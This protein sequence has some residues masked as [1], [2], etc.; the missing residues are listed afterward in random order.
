MLKKISLL[1]IA[2]IVF[3]GLSVG[4]TAEK[5]VTKKDIQKQEQKSFA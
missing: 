1:L 3:I 5:N 2:G 4:I